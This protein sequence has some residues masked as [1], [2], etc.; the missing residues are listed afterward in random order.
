MVTKWDESKDAVWNLLWGHPLSSLK[1][2]SDWGRLVMPGYGQISNHFQE[3]K[4]R[5]FGDWWACQPHLGPQK[6]F[7]TDLPRSPF[8]NYEIQGDLEQ[9]LWIYGGKTGLDNVS[10]LADTPCCR[11]VMEG[12]YHCAPQERGWHCLTEMWS[13]LLQKMS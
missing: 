7:R 9:P 5:G 13:C 12:Y 1:G 11:I 3:G 2:G 10:I 8:Q 4:E 6:R